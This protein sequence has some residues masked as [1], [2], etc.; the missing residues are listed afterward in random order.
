[1]HYQ[2]AYFVRTY[3]VRAVSLPLFASTMPLEFENT[4]NEYQISPIA[5]YNYGILPLITYLTLSIDNILSSTE[6]CQTLH[7][8]DPPR[9]QF[10]T[11]PCTG[12]SLGL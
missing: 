10:F 1:M 5:F 3:S 4:H 7:S 9:R 12:G 6:I 8:L 11:N 2:L